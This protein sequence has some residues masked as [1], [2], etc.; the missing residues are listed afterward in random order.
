[1][2]DEAFIIGS[3]DIQSLA[4]LNNSVEA[5]RNMQV[6]PFGKK[7]ILQT[8]LVALLLTM[9]SLQ[10]LVKR[11]II[12]VLLSPKIAFTALVLKITLSGSIQTPHIPMPVSPGK[13][14]A[15]TDCRQC[16]HNNRIPLNL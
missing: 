8:T 13:V 12:G 11:L 9:I 10:D 4:D 7:T 1:M 16:A 14:R 2:L 5:I 15:R 3:G 6:F